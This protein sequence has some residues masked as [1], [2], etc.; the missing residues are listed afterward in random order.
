MNNELIRLAHGAGGRLT[1]ELV[2]ELFLDRFR[3]PELATLSDSSRLETGPGR[4]YF[5]TDSYVVSPLFF[6]GG[7]IGS[8]AVHG[9]VNDLAMNGARPLYLSAGFILEEG[10]ERKLLERVVDSMARAA[11]AAGVKI[12]TGDTKVVPKG[13]ADGLYLNTAGIGLRP[14]AL[15]LLGPEAIRKGDAILINGSIG[16]HGAAIITA[17][18]AG[19][20]NCSISSDSAALW[21]LVA[22]LETG[23]VRLHALRDATR[24]GLGGILAELADQ[25]GAEFLIGE[26]KIPV[27]E[28]VRGVCEIFGFDP[29]FLANEGKMVIFCPADESDSALEILHRHPLGRQAAVI[30]RVTAAGSSR[31][32]VTLETLIGGHRLIDQPSGELVPRIC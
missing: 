4:L 8:L 19:F 31:P 26:E 29:L 23:G 14:E 17:R 6:P 28:E 22:A 30:G 5:T 32:R 20:E 25:A 15:P 24:G 18:E 11:D 13:L 21:E 9:T 10:L 12:V 27:R 1:G 16:D 3:N 2:E 7:D